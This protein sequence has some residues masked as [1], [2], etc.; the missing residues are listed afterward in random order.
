MDSSEPSALQHCQLHRQQ[1]PSQALVLLNETSSCGVVAACLQLAEDVRDD[2]LPTVVGAHP[3]LAERIADAAV[4]QHLLPLQ[5]Q[6]QGYTTI[7]KQQTLGLGRFDFVLCYEDG[8]R[9]LVEVKNVVCADFPVD[10]VPANRG[11]VGVMDV[12]SFCGNLCVLPLS[13]HPCQLT[14]SYTI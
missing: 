2:G 4:Q 13:S 9:L 3:S 8:R 12:E 1:T 7:L 11:K 6:L 10:Q 14:S 5:P